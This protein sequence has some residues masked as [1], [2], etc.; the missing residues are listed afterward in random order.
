MA[1]QLRLSLGGPTSYA[2]D[3]F[4]RGAANAAAR[5]ALESWPAWHGGC[6]ALIGPEGVGK[7]HLGRIWAAA[8]G[9]VALDRSSPDISAAAGRPVLLEDVDQGIADEALFHLINLA[10]RE[11]GGLLLTART[12]P[13]TWPAALPDLRSRLKAMPVAEIEPPDDVVLEG[14]LR[15]FFRERSI[16]PPKEVYAY[17]LRRIERSV[18]QARE[19]VRRLDEGVD[20]EA[21]P[22]SRLLAREVLE[23]DDQN[24]DLFE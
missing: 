20:G 22:I 15:K 12:P 18:P 2:P 8:N 9:A 21:R 23:E 7:T 1:R 10:A 14:V 3:A 11:G 4:V 6:L 17:L 5:Q 16:R 24:L 19:I 13:A